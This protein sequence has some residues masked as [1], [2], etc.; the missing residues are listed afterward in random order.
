MSKKS[1]TISFRAVNDDHW[2]IVR[3]F[4]LHRKMT[5]KAL[6]LAAIDEYMTRHKQKETKQREEV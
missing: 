2:Q 4:A 3:E 1:I 5:L 6:V